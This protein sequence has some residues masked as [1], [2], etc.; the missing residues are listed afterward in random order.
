MLDLAL[1]IPLAVTNNKSSTLSRV[2]G[3]KGT[4][5]ERMK[6]SAV[7]TLWNYQG[8]VNMLKYVLFRSPVS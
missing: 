6:Y 7:A 5:D 8:F 1:I 4:T 3:I 2:Q